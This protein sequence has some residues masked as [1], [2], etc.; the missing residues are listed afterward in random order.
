MN[1][2]EWRRLP[3]AIRALPVDPRRALPIPFTT[4]ILPDGTGQWGI[5][6]T[7]AVERCWRERLCGVCGRPL[8]QWIAFVGGPGSADRFRGA[9]T[10]P[11]MHERCAELSITDLCPYIMRPRVP[12]RSETIELELAIPRGE[13]PG[14]AGTGPDGA[15]VMIICK[16]DLC[17]S[18]VQR[19][20][21]GDP[22]RV[23]QTGQANPRRE[24]RWSYDGNHLVESGAVR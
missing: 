1:H 3:E 9:Y 12:R 6:D 11:W 10:D 15:W 16:R 2:E 5:T 13:Q 14:R 22:I 21:N 17:T 18:H 23:F 24:R 7:Q 4:P 20:T 8:G 19:A